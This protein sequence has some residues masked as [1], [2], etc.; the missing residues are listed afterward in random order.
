MKGEPLGAS[1]GVK[2]ILLRKQQGSRPEFRTKSDKSYEVEI[3]I[4]M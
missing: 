2:T 1:T 3:V 4:S